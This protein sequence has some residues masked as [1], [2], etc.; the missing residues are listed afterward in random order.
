[1]DASTDQTRVEA[2]LSVTLRQ[3]TGAASDDQAW[4]SIFTYYNGHARGLEKTGYHAGEIVAVKV[5]LNN[6]K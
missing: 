5:N 3:L 2:M 4:K 1:M 6:R